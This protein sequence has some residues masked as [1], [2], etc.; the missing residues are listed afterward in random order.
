MKLLFLIWMMFSISAYSQ[1]NGCARYEGNSAFMKSLATVAQNMNYSLEE[2]CSHP[3][4]LDIHVTNTRLNH[5]GQWAI[6]H[7]WI[8]LHYNEYSCQYYVR[9]DDF[10]VTRKNCYNTW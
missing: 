7:F 5:D 6:P 3:R 4:I 2:L 9:E 1:E 8:S 10:I